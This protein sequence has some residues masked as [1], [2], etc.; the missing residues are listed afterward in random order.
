MSFRLKVKK[1]LKA[2]IYTLN[3]KIDILKDKKLCSLS[4]I[5]KKKKRTPPPSVHLENIFRLESENT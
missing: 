5:Q 2:V 1:I 4:S 3:T